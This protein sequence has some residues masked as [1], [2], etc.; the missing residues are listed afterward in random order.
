M[1]TIHLA[2]PADRMSRLYELATQFGIT[3]EDLVR[4]SV[5]AMIKQPEAHIERLVQEAQKT[6]PDIFR[7]LA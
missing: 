1:G 5:E 2:L 4:I 6:Q 7:R 3:P